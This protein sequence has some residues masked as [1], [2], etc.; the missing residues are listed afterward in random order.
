MR[1]ARSQPT[2]ILAALAYLAATSL[3]GLLHDHHHGLSHSESAA[4]ELNHSGHA[5]PADKS[6]AHENDSSTPLS[7][8]DCLACRLAAQAGL[9]HLPAPEPGLCPL[10]V[11]L[12]SAPPIFF[13][14]PVQTCG[15]ARAPPMI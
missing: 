6:P 4:C 9:V 1:F 3:G 5:L 14:A 2:A 15:L 13:V 8:E 10:V 7:D 11:E 12:R